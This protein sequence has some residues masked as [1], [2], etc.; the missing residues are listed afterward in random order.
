MP[1]TKDLGKLR[2]EFLDLLDDGE[3]AWAEATSTER[4]KTVAEDIF[5]RMVVGWEGFISEWF[6]GA[7]NH[8]ATRFKAKMEQRLEQW[9]Q[10]AIAGSDHA[11]F[12]SAFKAPIV[13]VGKN[14][15]VATVRHLLDPGEGNI[16]F[17]SLEEL[18]R[19]SADLL[20]RRFV[21]RVGRVQ[22]AGGDEIIDA[23]L[24]IRNVLAH[25]SLKA[26]RVMNARVAAFP[27]YPM[28]RKQSMSKDGIGTYLSA[29]TGGGDARLLIFKIEFERIA[30]VLVP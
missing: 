21:E 15:T 16:E 10:D 19:R 23:A 14:P 29:R 18:L 13:A 27:T 7:V 24:A 28:L 9:Q 26:V 22:G 1:R 30:S 3:E 8:D 12:A 5:L 6:I 20:V 4:R 2:D 17:R 11:R 25:R